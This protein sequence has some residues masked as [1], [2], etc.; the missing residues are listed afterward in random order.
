M[1]TPDQDQQYQ[2]LQSSE[3]ASIALGSNTAPTDSNVISRILSHRIVGCQKDDL[4]SCLFLAC[5]EDSTDE[6]WQAVYSI[7]HLVLFREYVQAH[8]PGLL[9]QIDKRF[10]WTKCRYNATSNNFH[11]YFVH[12][13]FQGRH[14]TK[15]FNEGF[16]LIDDSEILRKIMNACDTSNNVYYDWEGNISGAV[17]STVTKVISKSLPSWYKLIIR[18]QIGE[19][20]GPNSF[21]NG[22]PENCL[23]TEQEKGDLIKALYEEPTQDIVKISKSFNRICKSFKWTKLTQGVYNISIF[24]VY[25]KYVNELSLT[26]VPNSRVLPC[27]GIYG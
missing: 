21:L 25:N 13:E 7:S 10:N 11:F 8:L 2:A 19:K 27:H 9:D 20:C 3:V 16:L 18:Q 12:V 6:T 14:V 17:G 1:V 24:Q 5:W 22:T 15:R 26:Y 23:G 4:A